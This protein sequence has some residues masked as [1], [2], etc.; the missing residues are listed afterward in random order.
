MSEGKERYCFNAIILLIAGIALVI[1]IHNLMF[2][3]D[4]VSFQ[5]QQ[6]SLDIKYRSF[7]DAPD[8]NWCE[9]WG[10][11]ADSRLGFNIGMNR[12]ILTSHYK[13]IYEINERLKK[14]EKPKKKGWFK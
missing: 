7:L 3:Q 4:E 6:S 14:I 1:S 10:E 12:R 5:S 11:D 13:K 9:F 2:K 8:P